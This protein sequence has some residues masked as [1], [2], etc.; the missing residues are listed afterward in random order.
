MISQLDA[1]SFV[2]L[3]PT[4]ESEGII[5]RLGEEERS[6]LVRK[7]V[8]AAIILGQNQSPIKKTEFNK[9]V[10]PSSNF[11]LHNAILQAANQELN[12]IFGMRLFELPDK[13]R[14]L[15]VNS[16]FDFT[17][18]QTF[19]QTQ[20]EEFT[21]LYFVLM[22]IF[23]SPD[24]NLSEE[25]IRN[26]LSPIKMTNDEL[27]VHLDSLTKQLYLSMTRNSDTRFFSWGPRS[28]AEIDPDN[29]FQCFIEIVGDSTDKDWPEQKK[30]IDKLKNIEN[31]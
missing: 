25:D 13:S 8:Q 4:T 10:F 28:I 22:E 18:Y 31:R 9:L 3:R 5:S 11:R 26:S 6:Q 7:F 15:L 29:F 19:S 21:V 12:K 16:K 20:C 14:Y 2:P 17:A 23:A 24:E 27:K 30:K 1:V